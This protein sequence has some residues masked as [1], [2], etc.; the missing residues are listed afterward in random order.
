VSLQLRFAGGPELIVKVVT[1]KVGLWGTSTM[2]CVGYSIWL[3]YD[4]A[5]SINERL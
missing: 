4:T 2:F 3:A 1:G 5:A